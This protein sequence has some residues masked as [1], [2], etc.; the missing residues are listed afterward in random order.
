MEKLSP[1]I[2]ELLSSSFKLRKAFEQVLP[3]EAIDY[4]LNLIAKDG[5][6]RNFLKLT[7]ENENEQ[8]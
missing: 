8:S 4:I 6:H 5:A 7:E 2:E 1:E 3:K